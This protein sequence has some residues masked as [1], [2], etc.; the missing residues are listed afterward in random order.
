MELPQLSL[1]LTRPVSLICGMWAPTIVVIVVLSK[2]R[3]F[4]PQGLRSEIGL[5]TY[6]AG[7]PIGRLSKWH[8]G[9]P[10]VAASVQKDPHTVERVRPW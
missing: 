1:K 9:S 8:R 6:V 2:S 7:R 5:R 10:L 4:T 3:R